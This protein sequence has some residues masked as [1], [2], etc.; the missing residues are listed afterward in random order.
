MIG[1]YINKL[2]Y[3]RKMKALEERLKSIDESLSSI[4]EKIAPEQKE[5]LNMFILKN[6]TYYIDPSCKIFKERLNKAIEESEKEKPI[7]P[8]LDSLSKSI[9]KELKIFLKED[10]LKLKK[11]KTNFSSEQ[12][13]AIAKRIVE[14][15]PAENKSK[16]YS[17]V[18]PFSSSS[19][20]QYLS[21]MIIDSLDEKDR[22]FIHNSK[23]AY[24]HI[25]ELLDL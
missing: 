8:D 2:I 7:Y 13:K 15:C 3:N 22:I 1:K 12:I 18:F 5:D 25:I 11:G 23:D 17:I 9:K 20:I 19:N 24:D 16:L 4:R 6:S 21:D 10:L 14:M